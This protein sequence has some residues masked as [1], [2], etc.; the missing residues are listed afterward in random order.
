MLKGEI[1]NFIFNTFIGFKSVKR[2]ENGSVLII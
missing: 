2:S 1:E